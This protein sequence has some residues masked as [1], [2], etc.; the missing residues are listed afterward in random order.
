MLWSH[1][2]SF[3][4]LN[5]APLGALVASKVSEAL[6]TPL[7]RIVREVALVVETAPFVGVWAKVR[8]VPEDP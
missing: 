8:I 7:A 1:S 2:P 3:R 4:L 6:P 5:C